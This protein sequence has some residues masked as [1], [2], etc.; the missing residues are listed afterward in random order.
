MLLG[1]GDGTFQNPIQIPND[2][3]SEGP[4]QS[5]T[6]G[7]FNHDG[8]LDLA[9]AYESGT[10]S[11]LL[12]K[13]DGTFGTATNFSGGASGYDIVAGDFNRDGKLD[14]AVANFYSSLPGS[15]SLAVLLGNGDGSFQAAAIYAVGFSPWSVAA[16]DFNGDGKLDLVTADSE[17]PGFAS[18]LLGNG[19][20]T[21]QSAVSY[22]AGGLNSGS[23][24]VG[25]FNNDGKLDLA[26]G[27]DEGVSI[28]SG[29]GDGTFQSPVVFS[30][31]G[32]PYSLAVADFNRDGALDIAAP[33]FGIWILL[34]TCVP[35]LP[36]LAIAH[37]NTSVTVS[38]PYPSTGFTL[39]SASSLGTTNWQSAVEMP[40]T[41]N[42]RLEVTV[43][44]DKQ[45]R[46]FRLQKQ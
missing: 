7:D 2:F 15:G 10:I 1:N 44:V 42:S 11:I 30:T 23:V 3:V 22:D 16:G 12:G 24:A 25:D 19:D 9:A 4:I 41:N 39:Q 46:Y 8:K 34:N 18:V 36:E 40:A 33:L 14:L 5:A 32:A 17:P 26:I 6:V 29:N 28:L 21:F 38:W 20:G 43:P 31:S 13:G 35:T 45:S 27:H 37:D